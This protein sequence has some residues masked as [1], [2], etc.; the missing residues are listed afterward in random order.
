VNHHR[1]LSDEETA[2]LA[3]L[4]AAAQ[5]AAADWVSA[6]LTSTAQYAAEIDRWSEDRLTAWLPLKSAP[7]S[8]RDSSPSHLVVSM[9]RASARR[10]AKRAFV[11]VGVIPD[12]S[13]LGDCVAEFANL[14]AG[15]MKALTSG[16]PEHFLLGLPKLESPPS[17]EHLVAVLAGEIGEVVVAVRS[18]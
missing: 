11:E 15:R 8:D 16:T 18:H 6:E 5:A 4:V 2:R 12:R 3:T 10:F 14:I 17:G 7:P 1:V 13:L 9:D